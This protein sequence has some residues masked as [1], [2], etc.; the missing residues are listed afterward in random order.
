[1]L[2]G[3]FAFLASQKYPPGVTHAPGTLTPNTPAQD[4]LPM[5]ELYTDGA[6]SG[7]PGP[8]GWA[9]VLMHPASG[10]E[11]EGSGG[12]AATTNNRME[13]QAVIEGLSVLTRPS[14]VKLTSD[15]KYVLQGLESWLDGWKRKGW[16]TAS[17]EPVKN[18][19]L[20]Q[21]LD[22]LRGKHAISFHWIKGHNAHPINER[23]DAMAVAAAKK[24]REPA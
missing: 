17:K 3:V 4:G 6:C 18:Q 16:K 24:V 15:S 7:N 8:G 5:V 21:Q 12:D 9:Y 13:L 10:S 11:R 23:C 22:A 2:A 1:M 14:R 20:W 19:D